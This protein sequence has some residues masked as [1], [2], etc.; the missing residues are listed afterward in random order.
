M[1][2]VTPTVMVMIKPLSVNK[3]WQ[4]RRFKSL[5]YRKYEYDMLRILP[6]KV[7]VPQGEFAAFYEFGFS[8]KLSDWDNGIKPLQDILQTKYK[9]DDRRIVEAHVVK[10]IVEKGKEYIAF[11]FEALKK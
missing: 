11:R 6:R 3:A 2:D 7:F 8:S 10:R 5:D 9:F 1:A 4:G